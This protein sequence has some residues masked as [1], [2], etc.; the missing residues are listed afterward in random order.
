MTWWRKHV[1]EWSKQTRFDPSV[2][3]LPPQLFHTAPVARQPQRRLSTI[4]LL[5]VRGTLRKG[6]AEVERYLNA[7]NG[8]FVIVINFKT[9]VMLM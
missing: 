4:T 8:I 6:K 9:D 1:E 2:T 5:R 7:D 3:S